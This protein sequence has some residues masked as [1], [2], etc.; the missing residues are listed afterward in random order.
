MLREGVHLLGP[1]VRRPFAALIAAQAAHSCEE[2]AWRLYES[3]PPAR[4]VSGL[5]SNDL[6][7]GFLIANLFV[8]GF[9]VWCVL[10]PVRLNWASAR[11]LMWVWVAVEVS[12]GIVH[13][14]WSIAQGGYTPGVV[15]APLLGVLAIVLARRLRVS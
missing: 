4:F 12:N 13:P 15:T 7:R 10:W 6:Q 14:A 5:A 1:A 9:G 2:Y 3:F 11:A 8:V